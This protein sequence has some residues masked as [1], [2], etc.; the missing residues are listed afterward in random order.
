MTR[1]QPRAWPHSDAALPA[2]MPFGVVDELSCYYDGPGEPN[3]VHLEVRLP[4]HLDCRRLREATAAVLAAL[5][6]ARARRAPGNPWRRGYAWEF[7]R[8][9][10]SDP[11][12]CA[13][14][15]DEEELAGERVSFLARAPSLDT[16]PPLRLMLAAGPGEDRVILNAHHAAFDGISCL[17]LLCFVARCYGGT[18]APA[19]P[20]P[21]SPR[22]EAA[23]RDHH[24]P[25][26]RGRLFPAPAARIAAQH[27]G[28]RQRRREPGYGFHMIALSPVPS[29]PR[30]VSDAGGTVND[31]LIAAM[32]ITIGRWNAAHG[33][34]RGR[35]RVTMPV[36]A[37]PVGDDTAVGNLSRLAA[38]TAYAADSHRGLNDLVTEVIRQTGH[39][40]EH[41]GP[42]VDQLSA[43]LTSIWFPGA[44]KRH[45]LRLTLRTLGPLVCDTS[46][47]SNLGRLADPPRFGPA[48]ATHMWFSTPAHMPR[49]LSVGAVSTAGRL[50]LCFRYRRALFDQTAAA[51]FAV[52]FSAA[53]ADLSATGGAA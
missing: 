21:A 4:G 16:S 33:R 25:P 50:H 36:G 53:L 35:I 24:H 18:D 39:A 34:D 2:R 12:T 5:P 47:I 15:R 14:W 22:V 27:E 8:Q 51:Q 52:A 11:V 30:A 19:P 49:G 45:L 43:A 1:N 46:L 9:P 31:L 20:G 23:P 44:V 32:I 10:D 13:S 7:P 26:A 29:V 42:Q 6:R 3:N 28:G 38:V 37:H 41:S 17:R 40:K 48:A